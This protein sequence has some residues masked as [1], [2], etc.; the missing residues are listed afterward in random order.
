MEVQSGVAGKKEK[1]IREISGGELPLYGS[2]FRYRLGTIVI[3]YA[4]SACVAALPYP[5][6]TCDSNGG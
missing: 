2:L 1:E 3:F 5:V 4:L 6:I